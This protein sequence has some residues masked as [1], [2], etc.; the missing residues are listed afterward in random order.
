VEE[1]KENLSNKDK[2]MALKKAKI[3]K[4]KEEIKMKIGDS[5]QS[6]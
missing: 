4:K 5:P 6:K 3:E 1:D 2:M